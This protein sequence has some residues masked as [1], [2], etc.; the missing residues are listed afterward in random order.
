MWDAG[1]RGVE[2]APCGFE[3]GARVHVARGAEPRSDFRK[4]HALGAQFAVAKGKRGHGLRSAGAGF[5]VAVSSPG[6]VVE[7]SGAM[8][9]AG[10]DSRGRQ[11]KRTLDAATCG[12]SEDDRRGGDSE[13]T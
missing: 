13:L 4:R 8:A 2:I 12:R 9:G 3:R 5:C 10:G 11:H 1:E 6:A 7:A